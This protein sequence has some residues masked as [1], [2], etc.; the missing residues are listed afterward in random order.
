MLIICA[1][2]VMAE[3]EKERLLPT[4]GSLRGEEGPHTVQTRRTGPAASTMMAKAHHPC[5]HLH[6]PGRTLLGLPETSLLQGPHLPCK[7]NSQRNQ[8]LC[9]KNKV[10]FADLCWCNS[11]SSSL[12]SHILG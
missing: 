5:L 3:D 12:T 1:D 8:R 7:A 11:F 2:L 4:V 6:A 10:V 9:C